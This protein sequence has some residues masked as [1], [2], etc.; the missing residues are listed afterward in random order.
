MAEG[1]D[2]YG[3]HTPRLVG[4]LRSAAVWF[5]ELPIS[6]AGAAKRV[7]DAVTDRQNSRAAS[8]P[9][10][11]ALE[12]RRLAATDDEGTITIT[13]DYDLDDMLEL[14]KI[15]RRITPDPAWLPRVRRIADWEL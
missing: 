8:D 6:P 1:E 9:V 14:D 3:W 7:L 12:V 5:D 13:A 11:A 10:W 15:A 2:W 4:Y